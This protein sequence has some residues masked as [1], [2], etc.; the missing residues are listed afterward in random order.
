MINSGTYLTPLLWLGVRHSR[1][2]TCCLALNLFSANADLV[3]TN[4]S[5]ARSIKIMPIG[6]SIT[7]DCSINGA[8][9]QYLQ[10]LLESNGYP[11]TFV[12]R[13]SSG[14]VPPL[15]TKIN[16]EGYCGAVIA[17]PGVYAVHGYSLT[18]AYLLKIVADALAVTNNRPDVVLLLIGT[19]D[20]GRGRDPSEVAT[21]D[22][23]QLLDLI[24]TNAP[25]VNVI[26][27]KITSLQSATLTGANYAD[28]ATNVPIYNAALQATVNQRHAAGQNV[29][30]AD[31]FSAV[32]YNTMFLSDHVHPNATGLKAMANEWLTRIRAITVATNQVLTKLIQ[33]GEAW[34]YSDTGLGLG[35]NWSSVS[36][37]DSH[38]NS[39]PARL[40]YGDPSVATEIGFGPDPTNKYITTYFRQRFQAP[41][42]VALTNLNLRLAHT[43]GVVVWLNGQEL[44][45]TNMPSGP[46]TYTTRPRQIMVGFTP[47]V[48]YPANIPMRGLP[49]GTNVVAVEVHQNFPASPAL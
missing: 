29:F 1:F 49:I 43:G 17:A 11:F 20:I 22:M 8:W 32:D 48:F 40:G 9:R 45:R 7:D 35:T 19:N 2:L 14:A 12:G 10:P 46:I 18:N 6:D 16:H 25:G 44:F 42:N 26:L 36:Y 47:Q 5:Q 31:M 33:A 39:G 38:W 15:F 24:F 28:Y 34:R 4:F 30:L 37:D 13:Q 23:A 27:A 3:L 21:N 41:W